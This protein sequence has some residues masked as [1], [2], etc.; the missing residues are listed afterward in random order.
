MGP[1]DAARGAGAPSETPFPTRS[2]KSDPRRPGMPVGCRR[3][4][5]L[6]RAKHVD[7]GE[8]SWWNG[9]PCLRA[10]C[11]PP[12]ILGRFGV[13]LWLVWTAGVGEEE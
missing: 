2:T 7:A 10:G 5:F 13:G 9:L 6:G 8:R 1:V 4:V 11:P 12:A 3:V